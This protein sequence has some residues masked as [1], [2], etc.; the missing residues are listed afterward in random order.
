MRSIGRRLG[1][2]LFVSL[3]LAGLLISQ[4]AL[5]W[6]EREQREA[7]SDSLRDDAAGVLTAIGRGQNDELTLDPTRLHPAYRRPLS[8]RYFVV[9]VAD[10][11]WRSRSLWDATLTLPDLPGMDEALQPGPGSQQLLRYRGEY[12]MNDQP[13]T[14]VVAQDYT[15]V[16]TAYSRTRT[17]VLIAWLVVLLALAV[18]QQWLLRRGLSPLRQARKEIEQLRGGQRNALNEDVALELHPL[19]LEINRLQRHTE[20]QL[21]RSRHALGDLGH[22]LKTPLAVLKN[23]CNE[24]LKIADPALHA[25]LEEQLGQMEATIRRALG[26][27]RVAA[28]VTA[29]NRFCPADHVPL[30]LTTL[31][32]AHHR[33]LQVVVEGDQLP[34][35]PLERDDMLEVLGNL[36][37]NAFKWADSRIRLTLD[38]RDGHL[39]LCVEDDGPGIA[40]ERRQQVLQRGQRLDERTPGDGLGLA[41]VSDTVA[42][43]GGELSLGESAW[44]GLRVELRLPVPAAGSYSEAPW[45]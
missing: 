29:T 18:V 19:V 25:L 34:A 2:S 15:P 1:I 28:G 17:A 14:I 12:R 27:A 26:R 33:S 9:E 8:G 36:L 10:S 43:Y 31:E 4:G 37:D 42:A 38:D 39:H 20:Q 45:P 5:W 13:V 3:L 6:L 30:L 41:I 11:R 7:L 35:Q 16:M 21:Q 32:R 24:P 22:A 40:P 23:R 44:G